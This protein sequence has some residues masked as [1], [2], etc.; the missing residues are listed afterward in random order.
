MRQLHALIIVGVLAGCGEGGGSPGTLG[1]QGPVGPQGPRGATGPAGPVGPVGPVGDVGPRGL[2]GPAGPDGP[3]GATGPDGPAGVRGAP[4]DV[5][6][7]G[8]IGD[9]GPVG[10]SGPAGVAG[11]I[12]PMGPRGSSGPPDTPGDTLGKLNQGMQTG[13]L[14][15][16]AMLFTYP[17]SDLR[18]AIQHAASAGIC[19]ASAQGD[20]AGRRSIVMPKPVGV[21][22]ANACGNGAQYGIGYVFSCGGGVAIGQ[23][24]LDQAAAYTDVLAVERTFDCSDTTDPFDEA[25]GTDLTDATS[26]SSYCCCYH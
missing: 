20:F 5:G 3:R 16:G 4:G 22:C 19:I 26:Y 9:V 2:D 13:T 6:P 12:G 24:K 25:A 15:L 1:P 10:G 17:P 14:E 7:P 23:V 11:P 18:W 21:A 8:P